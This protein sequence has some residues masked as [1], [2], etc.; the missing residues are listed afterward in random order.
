MF[1]DIKTYLPRLAKLY[2]SLNDRRS[3][4]LI[5]FSSVLLNSS[6]PVS[7]SNLDPFIFYFAIGGDEAPSA[8]TS[9]LVSFLNVGK[10]VCSSYNNFLIF[11]GNVKENGEV[12]R[13][14]VQLL[15]DDVR[16]LEKQVFE[17]MKENG[18]SV[19]VS[20]QLE[21]L[22]NDMK[23][24]AFLAGELSNSSWYPCTFGNVSKD[25]ISRVDL[26]FGGDGKEDW[27]PFSYEER[28]RHAKLVEQKKKTW[29]VKVD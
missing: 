15:M 21:L 18:K 22:P 3:D 19:F 8:G 2:L 14:Y 24:L 9:F 26:K 11:A 1:R 7:N 17:I 23:M 6:V 10:R 28:I 29:K 27:K 13:R 16:S 4:K 5:N 20:F 25:T 12:V